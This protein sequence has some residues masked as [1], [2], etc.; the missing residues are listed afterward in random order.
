MMICSDCT[1]E[2]KIAELMVVKDSFQLS[3]VSHLACETSR[4]YFKAVTSKITSKVY[5]LL[6]LVYLYN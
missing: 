4:Q 5:D 2:V 3:M 6:V 1:N